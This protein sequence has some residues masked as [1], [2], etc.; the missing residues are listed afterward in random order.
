MRRALV[1][2]GGGARG[3]YQAGMLQELVIN[4]GLDFQ[5]LRGVSVGALNAA[6]LAQ[7]STQ[8]GSLSNLKKKVS[9]FII[10]G[11]MRS[12]VITAFMQKKA[13]SQA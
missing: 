3:A 7:A 10:C 5:I 13:V 1:L 11:D 4:K 12:R 2:A 8:A 6:F 9:R